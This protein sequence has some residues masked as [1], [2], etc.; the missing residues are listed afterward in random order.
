[1]KTL[2][3]TLGAVFLSSFLGASAWAQPRWS[4][5]YRN[6]LPPGL[7]KRHGNLPPGLQK[8]LYRNGRLP[9]GLERRYTTRG[10]YYQPRYFRNRDRDRAWDRAIWRSNDRGR[11][12]YWR[13]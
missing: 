13:Y 2:I 10:Y 3:G 5:P 9:P 4:S 6:N 12:M 7:A 8:Q 11:I 1:M